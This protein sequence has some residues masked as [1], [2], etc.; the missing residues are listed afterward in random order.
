MLL[1]TLR[2]IHIRLL[3]SFWMDHNNQV[4]AIC[5]RGSFWL[6]LLRSTSQVSELAR[7]VIHWL[8]TRI[9]ANDF[10]QETVFFLVLFRKRAVLE[11]DIVIISCLTVDDVRSSKAIAYQ[12]CTQCLVPPSELKHTATRLFALVR[13]YYV[14]S[15]NISIDS[16]WRDVGKGA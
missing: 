10:A 1:S 11:M 2:L 7:I 15:A 14:L 12:T 4:P 16:G 5:K 6:D 8:F 3:S 9:A 13:R